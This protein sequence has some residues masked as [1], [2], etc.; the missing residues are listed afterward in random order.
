MSSIPAASSIRWQVDIL[1][2]GNL[3]MSQESAFRGWIAARHGRLTRTLEAQEDI[4][5]YAQFASLGANALFVHDWVM[6]AARDADRDR[7]DA[8]KIGVKGHLMK[9]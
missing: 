5:W 8:I 3:L 9:I 1:V 4:V 6:Q 2:R 7:I